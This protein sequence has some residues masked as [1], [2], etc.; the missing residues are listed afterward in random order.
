MFGNFPA[1]AGVIAG[2]GTNV[3]ASVQW[4]FNDVIVLNFGNSGNNYEDRPRINFWRS[5]SSLSD[6]RYL[7][8]IS[9]GKDTLYPSPTGKIVQPW[10][11]RRTGIVKID[12]PIKPSAGLIAG[13]DL[14][15][16][17]WAKP[18]FLYPPFE[19]GWS[20][21]ADINIPNE[22]KYQYQFSGQSINII[23]EIN[24]ESICGNI[25]LPSCSLPNQNIVYSGVNGSGCPIFGCITS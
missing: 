24:S 14:F 8:F 5:D 13:I 23:I 2:Y 1:E 22:I 12:I 16:H 20:S 15:T 25:N 11:D 9:G 19:S 4:N 10:G 18:T 6:L 7:Y 17:S 3:N 21:G